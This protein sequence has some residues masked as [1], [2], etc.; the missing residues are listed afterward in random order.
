MRFARFID[1]PNGSLFCTGFQPVDR[2]SSTPRVMILPP[3]GEEMNKSRHVLAA[4]VRQL[5][6]AGFVVILGDLSG[7]GDSAGEFA[8]ASIGRWR[9]DIDTLLDEFAGTGPLNL[10]GLRFGALLAADT[11]QRHQ[12]DQIALLH[13]VCD[14]KQQLTQL[15]RLR[16]AAGLMG[17]DQGSE[18]M[19]DLNARLAAGEGVE[20]AGYLVSSTLAKE[21]PTLRLDAMSLDNCKRLAWFEVASAPD[22]PLMPVS[23]RLLDRWGGRLETTAE[24]IA[25]DQFWITQEIAP[26]A[27]LA[28]RVGQ[29]LHRD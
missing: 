18:R 12:V 23:Q 20:A 6:G 1:G 22:R 8:E 17:N 7:T 5:G 25:C 24:V 3:F 4:L 15:L 21:M 26:C 13:P 16:L 27:I 29:W 10:I 14:G 11:A 9:A 19:A 28:D 2:I